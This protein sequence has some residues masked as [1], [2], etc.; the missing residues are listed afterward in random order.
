MPLDPNLSE[1]SEVP[2]FVLNS[3]NLLQYTRNINGRQSYA[4]MV[5]VVLKKSLG[6]ESQFAAKFSGKFQCNYKIEQKNERRFK[7]KKNITKL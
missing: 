1:V 5:L 3:L 6:Q 4:F 7:K 2:N